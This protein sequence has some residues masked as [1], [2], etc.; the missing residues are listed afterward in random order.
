MAKKD[1][2]ELDTRKEIYRLV[3]ESPGLHYREICRRLDINASVVEYHLKY[4]LDRDLL[5]A[6]REGRYK[7]FYPVGEI[8]ARDKPIIGLIRQKVVRQILIHVL[9][10]PGC[11]HKDIGE[12]VDIALST[13][14]FHIS[15]LEDADILEKEKKGR[16]HRYYVRGEE[17]VADL[18]IMYQE[19]FGDSLVDSFVDL[20]SELHP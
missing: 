4:L 3:S 12:V 9:V 10:N 14:S 5:M 1:A 2:L 16:S 11:S 7:R 18:L 6:K 15:K 17:K 20:W 8:D 19:S 13:L